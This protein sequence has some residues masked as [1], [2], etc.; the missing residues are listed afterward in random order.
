MFLVSTVEHHR[1]WSWLG[2]LISR[3]NIFTSCQL[4]QHQ[5]EI[6]VSKSGFTSGV[7]NSWCCCVKK[8][9]VWSFVQW[10]LVDRTALLAEVQVLAWQ[11]SFS[12][13]WYTDTQ[14]FTLPWIVTS[15]MCIMN[16]FL[17]YR[18]LYDVNLN[19]FTDIIVFRL[20]GFP[21]TICSCRLWIHNL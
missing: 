3:A 1:V 5:S 12:Y 8:P 18:A 2:G 13:R 11:L 20:N 19:M 14:I 21:H 16:Q 9:P 10:G 15:L 17:S 6:R 7:N 4:I